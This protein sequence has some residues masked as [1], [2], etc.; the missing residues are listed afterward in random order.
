MNL[1]ELD[2]FFTALLCCPESTP[3]SQYYAVIKGSE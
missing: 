2:G 1:E 3:P